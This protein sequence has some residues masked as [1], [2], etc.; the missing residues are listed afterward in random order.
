MLSSVNPLIRVI[1][2]ALL[3][4]I[5]VLPAAA[6]RISAELET[7]QVT[8]TNGVADATFKVVVT[9]E[10][11]SALAGVWLVFEDGFEVSIGDVAAESS[12]ASESNTRT[13]DLSGHIDSLNLSLP[14]TL[15]YAVDGAAVE[16]K[17]SITLRLQQQ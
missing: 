6:Q 3:W 16:Q 12:S 15:K 14:A 1:S 4:S 17:T 11:G 7:S 5:S 2:I 10:E 9:N 13:F 8:V